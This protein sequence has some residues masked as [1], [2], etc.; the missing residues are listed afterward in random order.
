MSYASA[1]DVQTRLGKELTPEETSLVSTR[2]ADVERMILRR[3]PDLAA[4]VT[5]D[6]IDQADVVQVEADAVLRLVRNPEGLFSETDGTYGYQFS[7]E[8]ASG[9]LEITPEE[10]ATLGVRPGRV[11]QLVPFGRL[12]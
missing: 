11:F 5:A 10:W 1:S 12:S 7:R 2:L 6:E 9:K 3:I 8:I 4:K